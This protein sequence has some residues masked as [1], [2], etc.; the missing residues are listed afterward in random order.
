MANERCGFCG[1]VIRGS[2]REWYQTVRQV[3]G[4][5][6]PAEEMPMHIKCYRYLMGWTDGTEWDL[7]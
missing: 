1:G 3:D 4:R 2:V 7:H 5:M 6:I